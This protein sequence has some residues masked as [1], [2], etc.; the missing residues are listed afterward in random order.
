MTTSTPVHIAIVLDRSGSMA[1]IADDV[2]G[3]FNTYLA[4]Q[5]K[6][7]G[8]ARLTL[9]QFD[10]EDPFEV[11]VDGKDLR[12]VVP[13][14]REAYQPRGST[15]LFDAIGRMI[16]RI[17]AD[18]VSR[19]AAGEPAEDQV[20]VVLTDGMENASREFTRADVLALIERRRSSGWVFVFLGADQDSLSA[21]GAIGVAGP[22]TRDWAKSKQG[23]EQLYRDLDRSTTLHREKPAAIRRQDADRFYVPE[24]EGETAR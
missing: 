15:P 1:S 3:G 13:L 10:S 11:L 20:V 18:V 5:Q 19:N 4:E 8:L 21:G 23:V 2:V 9:A 14:A 17:D 7:R 22:N 16:A 24:E 6:V 12:E